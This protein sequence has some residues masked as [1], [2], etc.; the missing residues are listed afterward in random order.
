MKIDAALPFQYGLNTKIYD[1]AVTKLL[2]V[3]SY[4][5]LIKIV[6]LAVSPFLTLPLLQRKPVENIVSRFSQ[7]DFNLAEVE[8]RWERVLCPTNIKKIPKNPSAFNVVKRSNCRKR[9]GEQLNSTGL[10]NMHTLKC[11]NNDNFFFF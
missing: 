6:Q 9:S 10:I 1:R 8:A 5:N 3:V 2:K 4:N 7:A 11:Q